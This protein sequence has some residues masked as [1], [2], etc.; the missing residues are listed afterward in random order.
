MGSVAE[1]ITERDWYEKCALEDTEINCDDS[2][3]CLP[4]AHLFDHNRTF[5]VL[6]GVQTL[7][8]TLYYSGYSAK[9]RFGSIDLEF[10]REWS[11]QLALAR[12]SHDS[13]TNPEREYYV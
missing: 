4:V 7:Y 8:E 9:E 10:C 3:S 6:L 1:R 12:F 13:G 2:S 11:I 5:L